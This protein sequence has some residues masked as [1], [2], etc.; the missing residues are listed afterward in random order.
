VNDVAQVSLGGFSEGDFGKVL[1]VV[2]ALIAVG[3]LPK[4]WQKG[5]A[6]A[7]AGLVLLKLL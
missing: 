2:S 1:A 7:G 6:V 3:L 4:T 5:V